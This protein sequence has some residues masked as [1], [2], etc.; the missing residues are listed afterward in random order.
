MNTCLAICYYSFCS[1]KISSRLA[2]DFQGIFTNYFT[3]LYAFLETGLT[4]SPPLCVVDYFAIKFISYLWI[5]A[6][7]L[8]RK[9]KSFSFIPISITYNF[10]SFHSTLQ[11]ICKIMLLASTFLLANLAINISAS[12]PVVEFLRKGLKTPS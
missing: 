10:K 6:M 5:S 3:E 8:K 4:V 2:F 7:R 12:H 9:P 1:R 11:K